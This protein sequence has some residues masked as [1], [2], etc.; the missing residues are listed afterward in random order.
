MQELGVRQ[1][2]ALGCRLSAAEV[3]LHRGRLFE[4]NIFR[5]P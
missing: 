5:Y 4:G 1:G 2:L 3:E